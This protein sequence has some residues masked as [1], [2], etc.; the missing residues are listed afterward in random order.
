MLL[1]DL[2]QAP[3]RDRRQSVYITPYKPEYILILSDCVW[4]YEFSFPRKD[5]SPDTIKFTQNLN[6][7]Q[8][9]STNLK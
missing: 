7:R 3:K 6:R 9:Q 1:T 5:V 8:R 2:A 4:E